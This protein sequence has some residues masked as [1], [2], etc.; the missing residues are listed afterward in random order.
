MTVTDHLGRLLTFV[1]LCFESKSANPG[2]VGAMLPLGR[3]EKSTLLGASG[4][5]V[6]QSSGPARVLEF[7]I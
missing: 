3:K 2:I 6:L 7:K 1:N 5:D 4:H